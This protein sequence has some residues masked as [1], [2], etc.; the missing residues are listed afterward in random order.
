MT[1]TPSPTSSSRN[2]VMANG[3][4]NGAGRSRS[5]SISNGASSCSKDKNSKDN[6]NYDSN[7][8]NHDNNNNS[9]SN[10]STK[11]G[12]RVSPSK[13]PSCSDKNR[14]IGS[15]PKNPGSTPKNP[16]STD[17]PRP[18]SA[19]AYDALEMEI[20]KYLGGS[21]GIASILSRNAAALSSTALK[22]A[23]AAAAA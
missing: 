3:V 13:Q 19:K 6:S 5:S 12:L 10:G 1:T 17:P 20:E 8:N 15:A 16:G 14:K 23:V 22:A 11:E 7:N 18:G 4:S 2:D 21:G 9:S